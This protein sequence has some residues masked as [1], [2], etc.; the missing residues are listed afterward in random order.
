MVI[1][2]TFTTL[3]ADDKLEIFFWLFYQKTRFNGHGGSV[4]RAVRLETRRS[5]VQPPPRSE[6][7]FRGDRSWNIFYGQTLDMTPLGW[8]GRKTSTQTN[9]QDLT[10]HANCLHWLTNLWSSIIRRFLQ[11]RNKSDYLI[12]LCYTFNSIPTLAY[13]QESFL[14]EL[15][16]NPQVPR[17]QIWIFSNE[18]LPRY[19]HLKWLEHKILT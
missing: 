4:G 10:V 2:L 19:K 8:L 15:K 1:Q 18:W 9:E 11:K 12:T 16:N 7:F 13:T 3:L 14:I 6:T 5:R 17:F